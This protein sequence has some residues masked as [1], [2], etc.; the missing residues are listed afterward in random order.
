MS[1]VETALWLALQRVLA[2]GA[3]EAIDRRILQWLG[4][5][6]VCGRSLDVGCGPRPRLAR[7]G[8]DAIGV[9]LHSDWGVIACATRLPFA[10]ACFAAVWSFGLLHH[11]SNTSAHAALRE[12]IRVARPGGYLVVFDGVL[13]EDGRLC[14]RLVRGLDRGDSFRRQSDLEKLLEPIGRWTSERFTYARTGLEGVFAW[15]EI[16]CL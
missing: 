16:P 14:A 5:H 12:M 3:D 4:G 10:S 7:I 13:P 1:S 11:L 8:L 2:P 9:D 6:P 15:M